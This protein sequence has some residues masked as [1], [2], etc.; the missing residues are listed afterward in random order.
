MFYCYVLCSQKTGRRYVGSCEN[1]TE[2]IRRHNAGESKATNR[3]CRRS[4][5]TAKRSPPRSAAAQRV[6]VLVSS[7]EIKYKGV[8]HKRLYTHEFF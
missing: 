8:W 1:L 6:A 4:C 5:S 3:E 2:R 7:T